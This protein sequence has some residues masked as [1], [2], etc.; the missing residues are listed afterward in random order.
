VKKVAKDKSQQTTVK[1]KNGK[2]RRKISLVSIGKR[3]ARFFREIVS[4]LKK[5]TWPTKKELISYSTA[6][7]VF[8]IVLAVLT[9]VIDLGL[10]RVVDFII[11]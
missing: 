5:V 8:V 9:L 6:V 7:V 10:S 1:T 3:I 11:G 2:A 4:E